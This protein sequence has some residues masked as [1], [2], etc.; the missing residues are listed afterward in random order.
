MALNSG[1]KI[2]RRNWDL[3]PMPDTVIDRVKKLGGDKPNIITFTDRHVRL[4]GD[5]E[6]QGMGADSDEGEV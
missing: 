5:I 3:I 6:N 4:I 2:V 1:K